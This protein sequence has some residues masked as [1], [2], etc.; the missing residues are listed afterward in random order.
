VPGDVVRRLRADRLLRARVFSV[1][2]ALRDAEAVIA[3]ARTGFWA[4]G[5]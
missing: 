4:Q 1:P 3:S 5:P 2:H